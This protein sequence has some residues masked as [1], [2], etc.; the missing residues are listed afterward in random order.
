MKCLTH[1]LFISSYNTERL[2]SLQWGNGVSFLSI[3]F[4]L[5]DIEHRP[6]YGL[7]DSLKCTAA[8]FIYLFAFFYLNTPNGCALC[9]RAYCACDLWGMWAKWGFVRWLQ[10]ES[11]LHSRNCSSHCRVLLLPF[12]WICENLLTLINKGQATAR[13]QVG[14]IPLQTVPTAWL[15]KQRRRSPLLFPWSP[16]EIG[17]QSFSGQSV[18]HWCLYEWRE[19]GT[20]R[21]SVV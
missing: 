11:S 12:L 14:E 13:A 18:G 8:A 7:T 1:G 5:G 6:G 2:W 19:P 15:W 16:W 10:A 20:L 17:Q 9:S 21:A 3:L 4:W